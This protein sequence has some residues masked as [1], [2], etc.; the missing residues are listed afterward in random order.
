[1]KKQM[2]KFLKKR[3][4]KK[5]ASSNELLPAASLLSPPSLQ[6][7]TITTR[8][9]GIVEDGNDSTSSTTSSAYYR[10]SMQF[11]PSQ[12]VRNRIQC[13]EFL[14]HESNYHTNPNWWLE[15]GRREIARKEEEIRRNEG[16]VDNSVDSLH[17]ENIRVSLRNQSPSNENVPNVIL[18]VDDESENESALG[19]GEEEM[20][21]GLTSDEDDDEIVNLR[22]SKEMARLNR[23]ASITSQISK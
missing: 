18:T 6:S 17:V 7:S 1:V 21:E 3:R 19:D 9:S 15:E 2:S 11:I 23:P 22:N 8:D 12:Q 16:V 20:K 10:S 5:M 14:A 4:G 13:F